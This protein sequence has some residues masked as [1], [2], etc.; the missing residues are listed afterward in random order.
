M[1][2]YWLNVFLWVIWFVLPFLVS[3]SST[4]SIHIH[5]MIEI[6]TYNFS[7]KF[8]E[9]RGLPGLPA[10]NNMHTRPR[11]NK[12]LRPSAHIKHIN[13]CKKLYKHTCAA[14]EVLMEMKCEVGDTW[15]FHKYLDN[16]YSFTCSLSDAC[17]GIT[18]HGSTTELTVVCSGGNSCQNMKI[19]ERFFFHI[20]FI[21]RVNFGPYKKEAYAKN[22]S[23]PE[24]KGTKGKRS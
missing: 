4:N 16:H 22:Y 7:G 10:C 20:F 1:R 18:I 3:V 15:N 8:H 13:L 6:H 12:V 14:T 9:I 21:R 23:P 24:K 11:K 2:N 19:I 17:N 5:I